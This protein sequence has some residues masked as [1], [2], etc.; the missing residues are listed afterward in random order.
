[1]EKASVTKSESVVRTPVRAAKYRCNDLYAN[2]VFAL[3]NMHFTSDDEA[4]LTASKLLT[5]TDDTVERYLNLVAPCMFDEFKEWSPARLELI[6][7]I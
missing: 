3:S 5:L 6:M 1:M 4:S 2:A 7:L